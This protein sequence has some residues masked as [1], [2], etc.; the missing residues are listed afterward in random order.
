MPGTAPAIAFAKSAG[1]PFLD[2]MF[3]ETRPRFLKIIP[4]RFRVD[5]DALFHRP[6]M[7]TP[8]RRG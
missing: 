5:L 1:A 8:P 4:Y 7:A 2:P 6:T 3:D